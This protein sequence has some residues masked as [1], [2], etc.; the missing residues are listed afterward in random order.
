[1]E[2]KRACWNFCNFV[3]T[4]KFLSVVGCIDKSLR[5][6]DVQGFPKNCGKADALS[7]ASRVCP[8]FF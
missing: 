1:M 2:T 5:L 8:L 7:T 4:G 3:Y 6:V